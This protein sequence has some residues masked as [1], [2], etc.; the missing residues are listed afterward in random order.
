MFVTLTIPLKTHIE[1]S[2]IQANCFITTIGPNA[3]PLQPLNQRKLLE[4]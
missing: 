1:I 2:Q 3:R 4:Q